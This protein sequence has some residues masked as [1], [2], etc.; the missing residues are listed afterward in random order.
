M[1]R[2]ALLSE[3]ADLIQQEAYYIEGY[4]N[5][6]VYHNTIFDFI[7]D[8]LST[9]ERQAYDL[10]TSREG[11][12]ARAIQDLLKCPY[13]QASTICKKLFDMHL[14]WREPDTNENG[15]RWIYY[16]RED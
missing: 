3:L 10:I 12:T 16:E 1:T 4:G 5:T 14:V 7:V 6:I 2:K 11:V 13:T 8:N 9:Q 15:F